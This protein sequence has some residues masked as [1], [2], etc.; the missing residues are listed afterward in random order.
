MHVS[1]AQHVEARNQLNA[2][3][4]KMGLPLTVRKMGSFWPRLSRFPGVSYGFWYINFLSMLRM[5]FIGVSAGES[6]MFLTVSC[7]HWSLPKANPSCAE[8]LEIVLQ[9]RHQLCENVWRTKISATDVNFESFE[10]GLV[11]W[12]N[13]EHVVCSISNLDFNHQPLVFD[14]AAF[15]SGYFL[16]TRDFQPLKQNHGTH[17][18]SEPRDG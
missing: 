5:T 7:G 9:S 13:F 1:P 12:N 18:F 10:C 8:E 17:W 14:T 16:K 4:L 6:H 11:V 2:D 15:K 3:S